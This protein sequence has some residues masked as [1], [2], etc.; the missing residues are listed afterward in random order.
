MDAE[1][2]VV[3]TLVLLQLVTLING[4]VASE[5]P[6]LLGIVL[7][8]E[9]N[10]EEEKAADVISVDLPSQ[11]T[12]TVG[13]QVEQE[14]S[15]L[16]VTPTTSLRELSTVTPTMDLITIIWYVATLIA[17]ISFFVV[18]ACADTNRCFTPKPPDVETPVPPTPAPS[19]RLFAPPSYES[20]I[21]K[22]SDSIFIIPVHNSS[23]SREQFTEDLVV[24]LSN[25]I[26]PAATSS[27]NARSESAGSHDRS[28]RS[29]NLVSVTV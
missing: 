4:S 5:D 23:S 20:V 7:V 21:D 28:H 6:Q 29:E 22:R 13:Y 16:S 12:S 19:Y 10:V 24:N 17:L 15:T 27:S 8:Q 26:E 25:V 1:D 3:V 11:E 18:M 14:S 2:R 9:L